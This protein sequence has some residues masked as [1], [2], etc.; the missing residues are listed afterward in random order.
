[1]CFRWFAFIFIEVTAYRKVMVLFYG[2]T[3]HI[4]FHQA[5]TDDGWYAG[6]IFFIIFVSCTKCAQTTWVSKTSKGCSSKCF[7]HISFWDM[8]VKV[9]GNVA[10]AQRD[11]CLLESHKVLHYCCYLQDNNCAILAYIIHCAIIFS[12]K[13]LKHLLISPVSF[14]WKTDFTSLEKGWLCE[15]PQLLCFYWVSDV[16]SQ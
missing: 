12:L 16:T 6:F 9:R 10:C 2:Y 1:M 8:S 11:L 4:D 7:Q 3:I 14:S 15:M 13:S 5:V